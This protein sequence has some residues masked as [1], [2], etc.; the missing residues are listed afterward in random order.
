[1]TAVLDVQ[2]L[3][4]VFDTNDGRVQSAY[5][6]SFQ[7]PKGGCLGVVGESGS[8]K[9]QIFMAAMGLLAR[10]GTS[11]GVVK[12]EGQNILNLA[13][14]ALNDIRGDRMAM[15]FQDPMTALTPHMKIGDQLIEGLVF[16]KNMKKAEAWQLAKDKL[17]AVQIPDVDRRLQ[18]YP[19]ELSG[20]MRQRV[21]IAMALLS[22]PDLIIADEPTTALDVTVQAQVLDLL[23][24]LKS[25]NTAMA[26]ISHN[27]G[28][29][30]S[31]ADRVLVMY[32]GR[33]VEDAPVRQLFDRPQHPYTQAL[34]SSMPRLQ[35]D[36]G[37][38][39]TIPGQPPNLQ[40]APMGCAFA[41]RCGKVFDRCHRERPELRHV[42]ADVGADVRVA[43]HLAEGSV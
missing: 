1:M 28:V 24:Q 18:Q 43:C 6:V 31:L 29:V 14:S 36:K 23:R 12:F 30:A 22:A 3:N 5:D 8:G 10:N 4:I 34:L 35:A 16:H 33:V 9:S 37:R 17:A 7:I 27:L 38:L 25:D 42:G 11:S 26:L 19:H 39:Q 41:D 21:M 20:G 13:P 40:K 2:N 15:I 32:A